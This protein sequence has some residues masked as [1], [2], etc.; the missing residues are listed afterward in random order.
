MQTQSRFQ[1]RILHKA[2]SQKFDESAKLTEQLLNNP[3]NASAIDGHFKNVCVKISKPLTD[4]LENT[5][6]LLDMTKGE[7]FLMAIVD[8][9]DKA[10]QVIED[11]GLPDHFQK[12]SEMEAAIQAEFD[13]K[14]GV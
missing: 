2:L 4:R 5:L 9:L 14:G 7:F 13:A 10:D 11:V 8:A 3:A 12:V 1:Q 6:G